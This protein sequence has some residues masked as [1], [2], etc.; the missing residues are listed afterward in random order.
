MRTAVGGK[1]FLCLTLEISSAPSFGGDLAMAPPLVTWNDEVLDLKQGTP[2][3]Y[4]RPLWPFGGLAKVTRN[5]TLGWTM[6]EKRSVLKSANHTK[7]R[8]GSL[9]SCSV[10]S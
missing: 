8:V 2:I 1:T 4:K 10:P 6:K 9:R 7:Q 3:C 5:P